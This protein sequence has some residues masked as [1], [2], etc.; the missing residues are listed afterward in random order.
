MGMA[1]KHALEK[2]LAQLETAHDQLVSE[3]THMDQLMH[4]VGFTTG[5]L[6][7]KETAIDL[8]RHNQDNSG[9]QHNDKI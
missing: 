5:L 3:L 6:G 2:K 1:T 9:S 8:Y 7:L 4:L